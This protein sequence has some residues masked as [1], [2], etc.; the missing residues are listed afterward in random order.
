M[1]E[2]QIQIDIKDYLQYH[3]WFVFKIHQQGKY[4]FRGISDL[5]AV[6]NG[7]TVYIEVKTD[8]GRL[9]PDQIR[10]MDEIKNH[11]AQYI[12]ARGIDD[13]RSLEKVV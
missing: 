11:G 13:V 1:K 8:K 10:F 12:V 9:S 2:A 3:G 7:I 5:I 6:K 4:A